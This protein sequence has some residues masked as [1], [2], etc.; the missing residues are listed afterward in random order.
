MYKHIS[1]AILL[2]FLWATLILA[3]ELPLLRWS[4]YYDGPTNDDD[5]SHFVAV[6][7]SGNVIVAGSSSVAGVTYDFATAKYDANGNQLW[8]KRYDGGVYGDDM[9]SAMALGASGAVYVSGF[10]KKSD[11]SYV[12]LTIKYDANGVQR[13]I[14]MITPINADN[15]GEIAIDDDENIYVTTTL[16]SYNFIT[17]KYNSAGAKLW[18]KVY[19]GGEE[20]H[21]NAIAV[22]SSGN[23]YVTGSSEGDDTN[24]DYATVKYGPNSEQLWVARYDGPAHLNDSPFA[25]ALDDFGKIY[26]TGYTGGLGTSQDYTT[27][28]YNSDGNQLWAERYDG[29]GHNSDIARALAIDI[30]GNV[31]VTGYSMNSG[32][33]YDAATI[34]Y[35]TDGNPIWVARYSVSSDHCAGQA[36]T[37]D[38]K[39]NAYITGGHPF[40]YEHN[41]YMVIKYGPQ[42]DAAWI[43]SDWNSVSC[44][45]DIVVDCKGN[46]YVTGSRSL[47]YSDLDYA[48]VK[49]AMHNYCTGQINSDYNQDCKVDFGDFTIIADS[50]LNNYGWEDLEVLADDWLSCLFAIEE[51]CW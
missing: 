29:P 45:A 31:F 11:G 19:D 27:I 44:G 41:K 9:V 2:L 20:D 35:S 39:G 6:D 12:Y 17:V 7:G 21:A 42:G 10:S 8:V 38:S 14:A 18:E 4:A 46:V 3:E 28:S 13:W 50:W 26:V 33:Y 24:K 1:A 40:F 22:D 49:Y 15:T 5:Y 51:D 34:K 48:T 23:V 16:R 25:I 36:I 37:T 47:S 32:N 30:Y 43:I